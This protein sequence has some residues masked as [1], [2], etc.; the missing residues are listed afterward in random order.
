MNASLLSVCVGTV[1]AWTHVTVT[2]VF[3]IPGTSYLSVERNV[4]V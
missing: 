3:A 1:D 4:E 2:D